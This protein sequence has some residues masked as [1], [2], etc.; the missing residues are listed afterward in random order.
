MGLLTSPPP[1]RPQSGP[2]GRLPAG[3]AGGL[4][5]RGRDCHSKID[6]VWLGALESA[7]PGRSGEGQA[8]AVLEAGEQ[9]GM[10]RS[11]KIRAPWR[12]RA[13]GAIVRP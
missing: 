12:D 13:R 6:R 2:P 4:S 3:G 10:T 5:R 9:I 7:G 1:N 11:G 8:G